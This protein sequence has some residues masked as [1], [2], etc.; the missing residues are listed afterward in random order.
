MRFGL[1]DPR[2]YDSVELARNLAWLEPIYEPSG[3]VRT[4]RSTI[5][6]ESAIRGLDRLRDSGVGAIVGATAPPAGTFDRV[7][8]SG[9]VWIAWL[10]ARPWAGTGSEADEVH[11]CRH[12]G[13]A[14][15]RLGA[16]APRRVTVRETWDPGWRARLDGRPLDLAPGPGPFLSFQTPGGEHQITLNYDP[17]EVRIGAMISASA[18]AVAILILTRIRPFW[19]PG[20]T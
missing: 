8:K 12:H 19:I 1:S 11:W 20:I 2:N 5:T 17:A 3:S 16:D 6:W 10:D 13:R 9:R 14:V 15:I 18:L 4:S 7:E